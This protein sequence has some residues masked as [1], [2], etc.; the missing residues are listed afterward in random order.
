MDKVIEMVQAACE[1]IID[2]LSSL[3]DKDGQVSASPLDHL[4]SQFEKFEQQIELF[5]Q[6]LLNLS[7]SL[8]RHLL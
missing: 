7:I 8:I 5:V 4:L 6:Y 2:T 3:I 1:K